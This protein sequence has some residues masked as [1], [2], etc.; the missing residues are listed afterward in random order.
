[1]LP[2]LFEAIICLAREEGKGL[3]LLA[4]IITSQLRVEPVDTSPSGWEA[5]LS[6]S[7]ESAF[8]GD[9]ERIPPLRRWP[10]PRRLGH[11]RYRGARPDRQAALIALSQMLLTPPPAN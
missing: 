6:R 5:T 7:V 3:F 1:M 8:N 10:A 4:R 2:R 11:D 9:I